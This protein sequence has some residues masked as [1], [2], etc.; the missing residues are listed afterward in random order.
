MALV[1]CLSCSIWSPPEPPA[2]PRP[3]AL[4]PAEMTGP[5]A[6]EF[7]QAR[8]LAH[9]AA[10]A[11]EEVRAVSEAIVREAVANDV[12]WDLVLAVIKTESGFHNFAVSRVGALGLM[13]IMPATGKILA[14]RLEER[15]DGKETLFRPVV[16][17]KFG[18][19]YLA[20]LHDRYGDW[21]KALAAY[22]WGP[23]HIDRR[24]RHSRALPVQYAQKVKSYVQSPVTP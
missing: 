14:G 20:F 24:L 16:N 9:H 3:H 23:A 17:V 2:R 15:W 8:F 1:C 19:G 12:S 4:V 7:V 10:L 21:D 22:N 5:S 18:T 11:P 13:Q 6:V